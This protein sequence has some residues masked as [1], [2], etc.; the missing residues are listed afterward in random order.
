LPLVDVQDLVGF[1]ISL[2]RE[3]DGH[4][5]IKNENPLPRCLIIFCPVVVL[6]CRPVSGLE[7]WHVSVGWNNRSIINNNIILYSYSN[8]LAC[9]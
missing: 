9:Q 6:W 1:I 3:I 4:T 7:G 8:R 5:N 2:E